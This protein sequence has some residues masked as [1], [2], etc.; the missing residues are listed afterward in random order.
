M[1]AQAF[2]RELDYTWR[3]AGAY[4][5]FSA[6]LCV[7]AVLFH[8]CGRLLLFVYECC[9]PRCQGEPEF[10]AEFVK[11]ICDSNIKVVETC[12]GSVALMAEL[13]RRLREGGVE[14]MISKWVQVSARDPKSALVWLKS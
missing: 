1:C 10:P 2:W 5:I 4:T 3:E 9:V 12:G 6:C 14:V 7:C 11:A 8:V 13:H